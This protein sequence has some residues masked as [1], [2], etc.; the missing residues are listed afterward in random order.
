MLFL[1]SMMKKLLIVIL[2]LLQSLF[3]WSQN[4]NATLIGEVTDEKGEV[5]ELV[6]VSLKDYPIGT[7]TLKNG[8]YLLR[9]PSGRPVTVVFSSIGFEM[10]EEVVEAEA[11][12]MMQL[13]VQLQSKQEELGEVV[14]GGQRQT[15]GNMSRIDPRSVGGLPDVGMGSV[16]GVLKTLAGVTSTNELSN[17]YSVRG[18]S[19]DENLV[20]VNDIEVYRPFLIR[21]GQQEGLSFINS[22]MVSSIEFSAGG[23]DARY[24]DKMS[25]VLNIQYNIPTEFKASAMASLIGGTVHAEDVSKNGKF[26]YNMGTRYKNYKFLLSTLEEKGEYFPSYFDYQGYFTYQLTDKLKLSFLGTASKNKYQFIPQDRRTEFGTFNIPYSLSVYF[27]GQEVDSYETYTGAFSINFRPNR[28]TILKLIAS[29]YDTNEAESYDIAGTYYFNELDN[30]YG[31]ENYGDSSLNLGIGKYLEHGRNL[32][33]ARVYSFSHKGGRVAGDNYLRWGITGK[34]EDIYDAMNEWEYRDS[35]GYSLPYSISSV[36]LYKTTRTN[37]SHQQFRFTGYV[38]DSHLFPIGIGKLLLTGGLRTHYWTYTDRF[39]FSPRFSASLKTGRQRDIIARLSFGWY[40][41]PPFYREL[42]NVAGKINKE[43]QTPYSIH[44]VAGVDYS[45]IAWDRP[46]KFT[47]ELYYKMLRNLIPYQYENV[48]IRYLSDEISNGFSTGID[49]KI[50][51][52]FVSGTQSW[53]S[54]SV[55][56]TME[57]LV[58]DRNAEGKLVG[59]IPRP[60][61]QRFKFSIYFEDYMP[62]NPAYQMHMTGHLITGMPFGPP[63]SERWRHTGRFDTYR[64]FDIGFTRAIVSNGKN[65]TNADFFDRFNNFKVS[66]EIFNMI[67]IKNPSSYFWIADYTNQYYPVPNYLT[68]RLFNLKVRADF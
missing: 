19:F 38:Q 28:N 34:I 35:A 46:F 39:T 56:K 37:Y 53:A 1:H 47:G 6:N 9:I 67:D 22:N 63:K 58:G 55:M 29:A 18:G 64:R 54:L 27:D 16:E 2:I 60:N 11:E 66:V 43:I 32:I 61:D 12:E 36:N 25:S 42:K 45:F 8:E 17:N 3:T 50:N 57:N 15:S 49:L 44:S 65:L 51:G 14:V 33:K 31:S 62:G 26:T 41:Q 21:S 10:H 40:H 30:D 52:E 7:T 48:R 59:Y 20:Y 13:S 68:G 24:G 4:S 5:L 23:F